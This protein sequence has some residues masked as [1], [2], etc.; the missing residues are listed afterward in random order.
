MNTDF[1]MSVRAVQAGR[2]MTRLGATRHLAVPATASIDPSQAIAAGAWRRRVQQA[3]TWHNAAGEPRGDLLF[4]VHGYAMSADEVLDRHRRLQRS[5]AALPTPFRGAIVSFDW[6][7]D[8]HVLAY[9]A[10][11]HRAKLSALRLVTDGIRA[12]AAHR[13]AGC[14]VNL[15]VLAHSTG[16]Y[17]VREAFD[18]ADDAQ[19]ANG[20][21]NVSQVCLA[22]ADIS[23]A[24]LDAGNAACASLYRHC[25]R[26][27]NYHCRL[28]AVLDLSNVKRLGLAPRAGRIGLGKQAPAQA[29]DVDCTAYFRTLI[30]DPACR[31]RDQ[32]DGFA[33]ARS[34]SW[35]FGNRRFAAD[36]F[37][38]LTG[39]DR[40]SVPDRETSPRGELRLAST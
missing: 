27:T 16:A 36:L 22:A 11:R 18:D 5:L 32:P 24:S 40:L 12:L 38:T 29:V 20:A 8:R 1:I 15:H 4:V 7:S 39:T 2:F 21:W 23:S 13:R 19:L 34:H 10:D 3:A 25:V 31:V 17:L 14:A 26:L 30:D 28:D 6:P 9:L 37:A 33:G 35:Y